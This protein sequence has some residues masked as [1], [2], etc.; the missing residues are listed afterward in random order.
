MTYLFIFM[1]ACGIT[2]L[3]TPTIRYMAL[4]F[5]V[6]DRRNARKIHTRI[7]TRF[8]G[9]G[10]Y[11]GFIFAI[12]SLFLMQF[13]VNSANSKPL[14]AIIMAS[15]MILIL[16]MYDDAKGADAKVKFF[17]QILATFLLINAG[18]KID[19]VGN[20][21]GDPL[22]L[23]IFSIPVTVLWMV[24]ITN[25]INL[26]DGLDGLA[27]GI[28]FICAMG[29]FV[30]FLIVGL[31]L[32]A[33]FAVSLAGACLGFL[34]YNFSPAKIFMGDTGSMFLGFSIAALAIWTG[35]KAST[36]VV[37]IVPLLGLGVP[38]LDTILAF[39][40]RIIR[41]QNPFTADK[42]HLHHLFLK[43]GLSEKQVVFVFWGITLFL[44]ICACYFFCPPQ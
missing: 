11:I 18:F 3:I 29:L 30:K 28:A 6:I 9:I 42:E 24:G 33:F 15:T 10:I 25:A 32:P 4:K 35:Q 34:R 19:I 20:P 26:I 14:W 43:T 8:G 13:G 38:V 44:N 12:L 39:S 16:G 23:G 37:L 27:V 22:N 40:R 7:V 2:F 36:A 41:R 21:W 1:I 5:S 31:V 17:V